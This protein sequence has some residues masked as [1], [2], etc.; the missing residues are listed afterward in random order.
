MKIIEP[1][2]KS[3]M[4]LPDDGEYFDQLMRRIERVDLLLQRRYHRQS[5]GYVLDDFVL[6]EEEVDALLDEPQGAPAWLMRE[7][8][9]SNTNAEMSLPLQNADVFSRLIERFDLTEFES[10]VLLLGLLPHIDT[11]YLSL[12]SG[13]SGDKQRKFPTFELALGLFCDTVEERSAH[14][15][16]L[17]PQSPLLACRLLGIRDNASADTESW[18][19][20][21][22]VTTSDVFHYLLG[23]EYLTSELRA[24]AEVL[25]I[26]DTSEKERDGEFASFRVNLQSILFAPQHSVRPLIILR[27]REGSGRAATVARVAQFA[28]RTT[29]ALDIARLPEHVGDAEEILSQAFRYARMR[30]ACVVL[31]NF[32]DL[33]EARKALI[34]CLSRQFEQPGLAVVCLLEPYSPLAWVGS[35]PQLLLNMPMLGVEDK[36][37]LLRESIEPLGNSPIDVDAL[38]RCF[39]FTAQTLPQ[40]VEE[41][42]LYGQLHNRQADEQDLRRALRLR[43]Q[44][45]FGKLAQRMEP[46]RQLEDLI[47]SDEVRQQ[48][49][50]ITLAFHYR[51][52]ILNK[53][54]ADKI[55]YGTGI[56]ALFYGP[57]GTGK[58][59]AAEV[60]AAHEGVDLI[61]V[62][63]SAVVNKYIGETEKNLSRIF[64][65]AEADAGVLFFDEADA[66]FG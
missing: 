8:S 47:V 59:M 29:L 4:F 39:D 3:G 49:K 41:A 27:G 21:A 50:E 51:E 61:K 58:T 7:R 9:R 23:N 16:C 38:S 64:D 63:L 18:V 56:S 25:S 20:K 34:P 43:S 32:G 62:D 55:A 6:P 54:F 19:H 40:I 52:A 30:G 35:I 33:A 1:F 53:G 42:R 48:L 65:L 12:F 17:L 26:D 11:R 24:C 28:G 44:Q 5:K 14:Q 37:W 15:I 46:K 57:S 22:F 60:L 66:L 45:H 10:N 13:I 31:R 36:A 2:D